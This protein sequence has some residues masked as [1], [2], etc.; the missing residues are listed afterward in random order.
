MNWDKIDE[1]YDLDHP[2]EVVRTVKWIANQMIH[3][4]AFIPCFDPDRRL[5]SILFNSDLTR[6]QHLFV[7]HVDS[8]IT[9]FE[10]VGGNDPASMEYRFNSARADYDVSIGPTIEF[11]GAS[12]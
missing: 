8:I 10:E 7:M 2:V 3:S 4:F 11:N 12:V 1:K 5:N 6:H 9:L